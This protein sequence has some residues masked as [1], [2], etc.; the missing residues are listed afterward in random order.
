MRDAPVRMGRGSRLR[1]TISF[2][3]CHR[4]KNARFGYMAIQFANALASLDV[5]PNTA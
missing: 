2:I 5:A 1:S 4:V 3:N